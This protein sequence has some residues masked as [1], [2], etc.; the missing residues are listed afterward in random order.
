MT[1]NIPKISIIVPV[2]NV[3]KVLSI[4][5][6]SVLSQTF[7]DFE[8]L[9]INDGSTD[10][11][12]VIC[13]AY[14]KKD[15]RV[16]VFHKKNGGVSSA[17]NYGLNEAKG[18][19]LVFLDSDDWIEYTFFSTLSQYID[20]FDIIFF[21]AEK[22]SSSGTLL[23]TFIP[24]NKN[25][26]DNSL[27][28]IV[29]SLFRIGLLGYMWSFSV[30][31]LVVQGRIFFDEDISIHEDSL[32]CYE[33]I[34]QIHSAVSLRI[35]PYRYI[36]YTDGRTTL[37]NIIPDDYFSVAKKRINEI[38]KL[39]DYTSMLPTQRTYMLNSLK[40]WTYSRCIDWAY[41]QPDQIEAIRTCFRDLSEIEDFDGSMT[42]RSRL[43]KWI[44]KMKSP[45]LMLCSKRIVEFIGK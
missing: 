13:D 6:E 3:E 9:L 33:C 4:C 40:Y 14:A 39:Q 5:I 19:Y 31:R 23:E 10:K 32:F 36:I 22:L 41:Q 43:F 27:A 20:Q 45:Y 8:L 24:E 11:S 12:G 37:S 38:K 1:C 21:G 25:T 30:K 44:I 35:S 2:Y 26:N 7:S 29:Y 15:N 34:E 18:D 17:R 42:F 28:D 16:K